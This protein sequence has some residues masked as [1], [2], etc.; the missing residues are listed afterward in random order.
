VTAG[1]WVYLGYVERAHGLRG[2]V[3]ARLLLAGRIVP[4]EA[5]TVLRIGPGEHR[6]TGSRI[7]DS[8]RVTLEFE[9]VRSREGAEGLRGMQLHMMRSSLSPGAGLLPVHAF[10]GLQ[11]RSEGF[12]GRVTDVEFSDLNPLLMVEGGRGTFPVPLSMVL[13]GDVD[14][15]AGVI[16]VSLPDG[17]EEM[18]VEP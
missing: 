13:S 9:D 15:D 4:V 2:R 8:Q 6:V 16:S 1:D 18:T 5:G 10:V 11:L 12:A 14:W 3:V 17:L 7:R